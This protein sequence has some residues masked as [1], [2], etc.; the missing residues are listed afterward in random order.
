MDYTTCTMNDVIAQSYLMHPSLLAEHL[1]ECALIHAQ[2]AATMHYV[3]SC[4]AAHD[5]AVECRQMAQRISVGELNP[6]T[7]S[8]SGRIIAFNAACTLLCIPLATGQ[9][10]AKRS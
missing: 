1:T 2:A 3:A 5:M 7:L 10:I 9:D 8:F 6:A 4:Q